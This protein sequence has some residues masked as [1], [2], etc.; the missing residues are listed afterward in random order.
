MLHVNIK[1]IVFILIG[2][3]LTLG[4]NACIQKENENLCLPVS[5]FPTHETET[6]YLEHA[7]H[8]V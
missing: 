3:S 4:L 5:L 1:L 6:A 2:K 7:L 8:T